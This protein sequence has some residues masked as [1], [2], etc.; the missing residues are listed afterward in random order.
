[1]FLKR[2]RLLKLIIAW[3]YMIENFGDYMYL[4]R[5]ILYVPPSLIIII[6]IEDYVPPPVHTL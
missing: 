1:M 6:N 3:V 5:V 4:T 2:L